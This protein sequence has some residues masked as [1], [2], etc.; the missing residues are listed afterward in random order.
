VF[1]AAENENLD[2]KLA[3]LNKGHL[4]MNTKL[5]S[6]H[7]EAFH[8]QILE[9]LLKRK[10]FHAGFIWSYADRLS[11]INIPIESLLS[12]DEKAITESKAFK[13]LLAFRQNRDT[14]TF[15]T[16]LNLRNFEFCLNKSLELTNLYEENLKQY[17]LEALALSLYCDVSFEMRC[18]KIY[19][20][21]LI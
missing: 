19:L 12:T 13:M 15:F 14:S 2:L 3:R 11:T 4:L 10:E 6:V 5:T 21:F 1:C 9:K 7:N 17:H 18:K 16:N 8:N 20:S